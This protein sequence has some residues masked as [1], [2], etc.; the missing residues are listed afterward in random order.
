MNKKIYL[1]LVTILFWLSFIW[2]TTNAQSTQGQIALEIKRG[3]LTIAWSW[4]LNIGTIS[5]NPGIEERTISVENNL[6]IRDIAGLCDWHYTTLQLSDLS[7]GSEI[8]SNQ[9]I[10]LNLQSITTI[11]GK[12]NSSLSL[13]LTIDNQRWAIKNPATHIYRSIWTNC[14]Y[15]GQYGTTGDIKINIPANQPAGTYRG[16]IYYLLIDNN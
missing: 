5:S 8:I 15:I 14:W 7:N 3:F 4:T 1:L 12:D 6:Q 16:K 11:L 10:T 13:W 9:N 2:F